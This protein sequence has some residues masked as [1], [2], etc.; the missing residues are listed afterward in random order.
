MNHMKKILYGLAVVAGLALLGAN[1]ASAQCVA[2]SAAYVLRS[3][4]TAEPAGTVTLTCGAAGL[5]TGS[6]V[7]VAVTG[8]KVDSAAGTSATVNGWIANCGNPSSG[9]V[10]NESYFACPSLSSGVA[11]G[12]GDV[13]PAETTSSGADTFNFSPPAGAQVFTIIGMRI[14]VAAAGLPAGSVLTAVVSWGGGIGTGTATVV[15][16]IVNPTLSSKTGFGSTP[17]VIPS[18]APVAIPTGEPITMKAAPVTMTAAN[19]VT[20]S[21]TEGT[22]GVWQDKAGIIAGA[23][24]FPPDG[25]AT[26]GIR[27]RV[28]LTNVPAGMIAY[29][30]EQVV[31][32][33]NA[34]AAWAAGLATFDLV[35]GGVSVDGSGG[36]LLPTTTADGTWDLEVPVSGTIT[37]VYEV[38]NIGAANEA[39]WTAA[40]EK[41]SLN[42]GL[43]GTSPLAS[44]A[45]S[46]SVSVAPVGPPTAFPSVPQFTAGVSNTIVNLPLCATYLLFPWV[47]NTNDGNYNTG[48]AIANTTSDVPDI[49]T[50][51]QT[52]NVT[53]YFFPFD[54]SASFSQALGTGVKPGATTTFVASSLNKAFQGYVIVE[55]SF[56]LAHGFAF[57]D[58]PIAGQNGFAEGYLAL[59]L[60][61]PRLGAAPGTAEISGH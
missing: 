2:S 37:L 54:G 41:A 31:A 4:G 46:A 49:G 7:S 55:C 52:G 10:L 21:F 32:S 1:N 8:A 9:A 57:I 56:S 17:L 12:A 6:I 11:F 33:A 59:S 53:A 60:T 44:G 30:P 14:N 29:V 3:E 47:V 42:I 16:G 36:A 28:Q 19:T 5:S 43:F 25:A 15:L 26:Q 27:F 51:G 40:T 18:C 61:N 23:G 22:L 20:A 45:I 24:G 50:V 39:A 13:Q 38:N 58:N 48:M 34:A 35:G